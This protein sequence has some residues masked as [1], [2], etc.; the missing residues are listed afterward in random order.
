[1]LLSDVEHEGVLKT[2]AP[3]CVSMYWYHVHVLWCV[4]VGQ[5]LRQY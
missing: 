2:L 3:P 5:S 1:M 4:Q